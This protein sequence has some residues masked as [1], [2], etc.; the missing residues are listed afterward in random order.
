MY[1]F[2]VSFNFSCNL[3]RC[4]LENDI[5]SIPQFS[6][7][8]IKYVQPPGQS[9]PPKKKKFWVRLC[10]NAKYLTK[11]KDFR[12]FITKPRII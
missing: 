9:L 2:P 6:K 1:S 12:K 10:I 3:N 4:R 5:I 11:Q 8:Y 7:S